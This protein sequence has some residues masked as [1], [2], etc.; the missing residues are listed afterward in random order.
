MARHHRRLTPEQLEVA[1]RAP[2]SPLVFGAT[3][4]LCLE[5]GTF[6]RVLYS[7]LRKVHH[8][9]AGIYL[10]RWGLPADQKL[11]ASRVQER[12]DENAASMRGKA[13][14]GPQIPDPPESGGEHPPWYRHDIDPQEVAR[15]R[16]AG[17]TMEEIAQR[18]GVS[19]HLIRRRLDEAGLPHHGRA[20]RAPN[21]RA[22]ITPEAVRAARE[23]GLTWTELAERF[24]CSQT[25]IRK[26]LRAAGMKLTGRGRNAAFYREDITAETVARL[27]G[28]GL[29]WKEVADRLQCGIGTV[30][31]RLIEAGVVTPRA[32]RAGLTCQ[33]CGE[34]LKSLP[35]HIRTHGL[36]LDQYWERHGRPRRPPRRTPK[37]RV[38]TLPR[39]PKTSPSVTA[40]G[41]ASIHYRPEISAEQILYLD[42]HGFSIAEIAIL[43]KCNRST[44]RK[45]IHEL[46]LEVA[47]KRGRRK[48]KGG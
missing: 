35:K 17:A 34:T 22:D 19:T 26:R 5:C 45:R 43:L 25:I 24:G 47:G 3:Q 30:R 44:V 15:A 39:P 48:P 18:H 46:G 8:I 37:A 27:V 31:L 20:T 12:F 4:I 28:Q 2:G 9:D 36:T 10:Q 14:L 41:P 32:K 7:H 33:E 6:C 23:E 29:T 11:C 21:Y 40:P 42:R 16:L 13:Q 1:R 38:E